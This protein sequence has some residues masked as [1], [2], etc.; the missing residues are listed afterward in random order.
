MQN[1]FKIPSSDFLVD[2][3]YNRVIEAYESG[4]KNYY[5][6]VP[7]GIPTNLM[8]EIVDMLGERFLDIDV[9]EIHDQY[10]VIDWS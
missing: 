1:Y 2:L 8:D 4:L 10:I 5:Y 3:I 6:K 7:Y 9:I